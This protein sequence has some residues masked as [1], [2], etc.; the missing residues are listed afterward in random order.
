MDL[1][2]RTLSDRTTIDALATDRAARFG[3]IDVEIQIRREMTRR[4]KE[5]TDLIDQYC[6]K[7]ERFDG[8]EKL[9]S[10]R[11]RHL[12]HREVEPVAAGGADLTDEEI[13]RFYQ[14]NSKII[15]IPQRCGWSWI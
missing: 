9:R 1:I 2:G 15:H 6:K 14:D 11:H 12:A 10:L 3:A 5:A 4:A 13:E 8:L 7:G